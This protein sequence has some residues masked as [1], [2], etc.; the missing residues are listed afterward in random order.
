LRG[1]KENVILGHLIPAG[2]GYRHYQKLRVKHLG[3][4]IPAPAEIPVEIPVSELHAEAEARAAGASLQGAAGV[5]VMPSESLT[6]VDPSGGSVNENSA[7]M[8]S[9]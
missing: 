1:L 8:Q 4:P 9:E 6:L 2:S 7:E 5:G 3:E